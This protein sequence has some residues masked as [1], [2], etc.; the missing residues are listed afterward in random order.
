[1]KSLF[2]A[3]AIFFTVALSGCTLFQGP[4]SDV[5]NKV[6]VKNV[7]VTD[8]ITV[9]VNGVECTFAFTTDREQI[10][11]DVQDCLYAHAAGYTA[12]K[13]LGVHALSSVGAVPVPPAVEARQPLDPQFVQLAENVTDKIAMQVEILKP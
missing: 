5:L 8:G 4:A 1:M 10:L 2:I 9:E 13:M 3:L 6:V 12:T 11:E 7:S